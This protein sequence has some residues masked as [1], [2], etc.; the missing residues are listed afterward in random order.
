M[1][2]IQWRQRTGAPV[3]AKLRRPGTAKRALGA[4]EAPDERES[5]EILGSARFPSDTKS[6]VVA[7]RREPEVGLEP[8][9]LGSDPVH[10]IVCTPEPPG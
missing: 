2:T 8:A 9:S 4:G 1:P 3:V 5:G 7:Q 6:W 10:L